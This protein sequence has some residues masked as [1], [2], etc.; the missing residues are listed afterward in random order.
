MLKLLGVSHVPEPTQTKS[1]AFKTPASN[2][3]VSR[4][5]PVVYF[6]NGWKGDTLASHQ[7]QDS[8][9]WYG[10]SWYGSALQKTNYESPISD[11]SRCYYMPEKSGASS[12]VA[13]DFCYNGLL[14]EGF[15]YD[16]DY[17]FSVVSQGPQRVSPVMNESSL[18]RY[19][20]SNR[21]FKEFNSSHEAVAY[22]LRQLKLFGMLN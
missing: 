7:N 3:G 21:Y 10:E 9:F 22:D 18:Q 20:T 14:P 8:Q 5:V 16:E 11:G 12:D 4:V 1:F 13:S 2:C 6:H 17:K 19:A 15:G